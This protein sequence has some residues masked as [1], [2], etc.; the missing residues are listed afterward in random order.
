MSQATEVE[1]RW[2]LQL[3]KWNSENPSAENEKE[4]LYYIL[5]VSN[6]TRTVAPLTHRWQRRK[7]TNCVL[8]FRTH[9]QILPIEHKTSFIW[10]QARCSVQISCMY[11]LQF[12]TRVRI[13]RITIRPIEFDWF[14][15]RFVRLATEPESKPQGFKRWSIHTRVLVIFFYGIQDDILP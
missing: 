3:A 15:V 9:P 4:I 2:L 7:K 8:H 5:A 11:W 10:F 14:L 1:R 6:I 13:S 12:Q